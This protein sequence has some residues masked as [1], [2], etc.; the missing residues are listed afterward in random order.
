MSHRALLVFCSKCLA[1]VG[2][3]CVGTTGKPQKVTSH[4][5]R[6]QLLRDTYAAFEQF[7]G[8]K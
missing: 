7:G 3:T 6:R 8:T 2:S 5:E 1:P 4:R